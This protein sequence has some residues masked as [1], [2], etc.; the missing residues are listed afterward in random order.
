M[1]TRGVSAIMVNS[2]ARAINASLRWLHEE[3]HMLT[4]S[5]IAKLK[6]MEPVIRAGEGSRD[7]SR[8]PRSRLGKW[9]PSL[10]GLLLESV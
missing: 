7:S 3:G 8:R 6:E 4:Q 9:A 2:R 5:R 10:P 1:R